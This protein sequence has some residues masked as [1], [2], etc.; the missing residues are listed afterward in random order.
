[1]NSRRSETG[2][3]LAISSSKNLI[4]TQDLDELNSISHYIDR[5]LKAKM[6]VS[7]IEH[8]CSGS[9]LWTIERADI[10]QL[11]NLQQVFGALF[12]SIQL[13][14]VNWKIRMRKY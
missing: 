11:A 12:H 8:N 6:Q 3:Y 14:E 5:S 13:I 9:I 2:R 7:E 10:K 1:M 4:S